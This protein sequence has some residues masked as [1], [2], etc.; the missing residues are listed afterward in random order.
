[1][2][3]NLDRVHHRSSVI[4]CDSEGGITGPYLAAA[5]EF[6]EKNKD[7]PLPGHTGH[8]VAMIRANTDPRLFEYY[9][10]RC[11][12][13]EPP[14]DDR[15]WPRSV[16]QKKGDIDVVRNK[17]MEIE[18]GGVIFSDVDY[19]KPYTGRGGEESSEGAP[20]NTF[21]NC[22]VV[23]NQYSSPLED[24]PVATGDI[25]AEGGWSLGSGPDEGVLPVE[26]GD[27]RVEGID[28]EPVDS[29]A[30]TACKDLNRPDPLVNATIRATQPCT[31]R[32]KSTETWGKQEQEYILQLILDFEKIDWEGIASL[33]GKPVQECQEKYRELADLPLFDPPRLSW[34][35]KDDADLVRW[36]DE[37]E[38][39]D[40]L[41]ISHFLQHEVHDC[42]Q[43]Y[44]QLTKSQKEADT[45]HAI[46]KTNWASPYSN[47]TRVKKR[48]HKASSC[49]RVNGN[50]KARLSK[51]LRI[52]FPTA[53]AS[54]DG[55]LSG[56]KGAERNEQVA[57]RSTSQ[58]KSLAA[59]KSSTLPQTLDP[60]RGDST[61]GARREKRIRHGEEAVPKDIHE[62]DSNG[63]LTDCK[64]Q[65]NTPSRD[66]RPHVR[67]NIEE[68]VSGCKRSSKNV[69]SE[70]EKTQPPSK[71]LRIV[72]PLHKDAKIGNGED[73]GG[74]LIGG[75]GKTTKVMRDGRGT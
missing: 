14:P 33:I 11:R 42:Q 44:Q 31:L 3:R 40:W 74:R 48:K 18:G 41:R 24:D 63:I 39:K 15:R 7:Q 59:A 10:K 19:R 55:A 46:S 52:A 53:W 54:D 62:S 70:Q 37:Y 47:D 17:V 50:K 2:S 22:L 38:V 71:R 72:G 65:A 29:T 66:G 43:R 30:F 20:L 64:L 13:E 58:P 36:V 12:G 25:K 23:R 68:A 49:H 27:R 16:A 5:N 51:Y 9:E 35:A 75:N 56:A 28:N 69:E 4:P 45:K 60:F 34:S 1:M 57:A 32:T 6:L 61:E 73:T 8:W 26:P 21:S 67:L